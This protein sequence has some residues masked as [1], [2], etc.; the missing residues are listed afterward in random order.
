MSGTN[1]TTF[2]TTY[3]YS[4]I[5]Y[6]TDFIGG[7]EYQASGV[8]IS[9]DEVLTASHVVYSAGVGTATDITVQPGY[10]ADALIPDPYN[11]VAGVSFHY[12]TINDSNDLIALSDSQNDYAVIHLASPITNVGTMGLAANFGGGAV[13]IS[14]YPAVA[15]GDQVDQPEAVTLDSEYTLY[16][17]EALGQGSSGGPVWVTGA[18]GVDNV[19]GLVSSGSGD[20]GFFTEITDTALNTIETWVAEDDGTATPTPGSGGSTPAPSGYAPET[21]LGAGNAVVSLNLPNAVAGLGATLLAQLTASIDARA[22]VAENATGGGSL[23]TVPTRKVGELVISSTQYVALPSAYK[24]VVDNAAG[25]ST[26]NLS[27]DANDTVVA[28]GGPFALMAGSTSGT[29]VGGTAGVLFTQAASAGN[30]EIALG[31]G[32]NTIVAGG[33]NNTIAAGTGQNLIFLGGGAS[34]VS[35]TGI[36]TIVGGAGASTV[37]AGTSTALVFAGASALT[38]IGASPA[39]VG[40]GALAST[41]IAGAGGAT[42]YGGTSNT[43]FF[44]DGPSDYIGGGGDD[45]VLGGSGPLTANADGSSALIFGGTSGDN[46]LSSG[47]GQATLVGGGSGDVLSATGD[48]A[49]VLVGGPGAETLTGAASSAAN[50]LF[51]GSGNEVIIGGSGNDALIAGSG[52]DTLTGGAGVNVFLFING[53]AGGTDLVT[54]FVTGQDYIDLV[55]YETG[56]SAVVLQAAVLKTQTSTSSGTQIALPDGTHITFAGVS[57]LSAASFY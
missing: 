37:S 3:P 34:S 28:S 22:V 33:G 17:G 46:Q 51:G 14:G 2:T 15:Y 5:V 25:A 50:I 8:M 12:N 53:D 16:D 27:P 32:T 6:I 11:S 18:N 4:S 47:N 23:P 1:N 21:V 24:A 43:L 54:D 30:W 44:G 55:N 20:Q 19:V 56:L 49:A 38:F 13:T 29:L 39:S 57:S 9:P 36:D 7:I 35:S 10:E 41:V 26:V 48:T 31:G 40:A 42:V 45:T 52:N